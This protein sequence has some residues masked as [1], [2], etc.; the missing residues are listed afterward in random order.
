MDCRRNC[1]A[2]HSVE[3]AAAS[4]TAFSARIRDANILCLEVNLMR[5]WSATSLKEIIGNGPS[6][7]EHYDL[8]PIRYVL[9]AAVAMSIR[10]AA[11]IL[12]VE[13]STVSRAIRSYEDR[14]GLQLFLRG[15][16]GVRLTESGRYFLMEVLPALRQ[17]KRVLEDAHIEE[18]SHSGSLDVGV[19]TT[20]AGGF[21][22]N[23][24]SRFENAS[25]GTAVNIH[26]GGREGHIRDLRARELD[27]CFVTGVEDMGGLANLPL[28]EERVYIA[29]PNSHPLSDRSA[30]DW[31]EIRGEQFLVP[32]RNAGPEI[33]EYILWRC[34]DGDHPPRIVCCDVH[35]ETLM[36]RV[37][38]GKGLTPVVEAW[39]LV[40]ITGV[41]FVPL[42]DPK[43]IV[44]FIA[45][46]SPDN[47]NP[48]VHR[49]IKSAR[50]MV[51]ARNLQAR[52]SPL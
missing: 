22:R 31:D 21:L 8:R 3:Q 42:S 50:G 41:K 48:N 19:V 15:S 38:M 1:D 39:K 6:V 24:L 10:Q 16:F 37:A 36:Q 47:D 4:H 52:P 18:N 12:D 51:A 28:W 46:W 34:S 29:M 11:E 35:S 17:V 23:L 43:D 30:I 40:G 9:A 45:V 14:I 2:D 49:I 13:P 33:R 27:I 32:R 7:P 26:D 25:P 20:L 5:S 44:T